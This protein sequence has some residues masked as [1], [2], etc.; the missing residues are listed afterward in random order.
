[1]THFLIYTTGQSNQGD[2]RL[3]GGNSSA[4]RVEIYLDGMWGTVCDDY[5]GIE[6]ANVV[7]RQLG[8]TGASVAYGDA[9]FGPGNEPTHLD[10]VACQGNESSLL[11]CNK[12]QYENC[13]HYEDAGVACITSER[14]THGLFAFLFLL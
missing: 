2:L 11:D 14:T 10:D 9:F 7:C 13:N 1:M 12:A 4:G 8:F 3:A 5:W 6:D